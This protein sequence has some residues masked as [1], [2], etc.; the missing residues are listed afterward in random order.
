[1]A[2]ASRVG[3]PTAEDGIAQLLR[4][5]PVC[6]DSHDETGTQPSC[7]VPA[8]RGLGAPGNRVPELRGLGVRKADHHAPGGPAVGVAHEQRLGLAPGRRTPAGDY[9]LRRRRSLCLR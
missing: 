2:R 7:A 5:G 6:V 3:A 9:V 1:M 8:A 4:G